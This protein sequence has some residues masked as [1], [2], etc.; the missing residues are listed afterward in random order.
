MENEKKSLH[1]KMEEDKDNATKPFANA[2]KESAAEINRGNPKA[3]NYNY[4]KAD[5]QGPNYDKESETAD[6]DTTVNAGVFK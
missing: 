1:K 3:K 6:G 2:E 5:P 4:G